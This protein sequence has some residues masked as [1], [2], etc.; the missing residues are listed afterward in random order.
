MLLQLEN[1]LIQIES[2]FIL[3]EQKRHQ[4]NKFKQMFVEFSWQMLFYAI[5]LALV[6]KD[7]VTELVLG[8][9][10][11]EKKTAVPP[12]TAENAFLAESA[13]QLALKIRQRKLTSEELVGACIKR[14]H[15]V[16][17]VLN[18][19]V[20]GPF[21]D[22]LE[23]ARRIDERIAVGQVSE[24]EFSEKPFLGVPFT[25]KDSTSVAGKLHTLGLVSRKAVRSKEDAECVA[26]MKA[27]GA[28][29]LATTNIPE[30]N[31]W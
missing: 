18:A 10:L 22:A 6:V 27:A 31:K 2:V 1:N 4:P 25:T 19:I 23:E 21:E 20:D 9:Y 8:W 11:G 16:N 13:T 5:S 14:M 29:V 12:L 24:D 26:L 28:I 3:F 30:V 15:E 7:K 17:K